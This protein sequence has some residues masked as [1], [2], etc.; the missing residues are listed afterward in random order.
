MTRKYETIWL[1]IKEAGE[2]RWVDVRYQTDAQQQTIINMVQLEK[3]RA[4]VAR[5]ELALPGFGKLKIDRVPEKRLLR[6]TL[7][8]SGDSL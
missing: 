5:R 6:F 8:N 3:S 4:N 1:R 7:V 2:G